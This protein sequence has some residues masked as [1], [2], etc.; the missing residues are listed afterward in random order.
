MTIRKKTRME[1]KKKVAERKMTRRM[2]EPSN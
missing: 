1:R 2:V